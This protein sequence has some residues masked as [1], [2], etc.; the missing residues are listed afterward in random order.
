MLVLMSTVHQLD[1][2]KFEEF[3]QH[4]AK[5]GFKFEQRPHQVFLARYDKLTVNLFK[6]GKVTF[7]GSDPVL[8]REVEWFLEKLGAKRCEQEKGLGYEGRM[9][10]GTDEVGKGDYFG[11]LVVAGV[12]VVPETE[13]A[14]GSIGVRDS[15]K[16]GSDARIAQI[17]TEIM[18]IVGLA[19]YEIILIKPPKYNELHEKLGNVNA[20]L[21]WA[22]ARA[23][24]NLLKENGE[25][26]LA[27]ADQFGNPDYIEKALWAKSRGI[28]LIQVHRGER[29]IAVA[30]ASILA[31]DRFL[32]SMKRMSEENGIEFP[33]GATNV[34][35]SAQQF[36]DRFG[37]DAL[38]KVAK[39]HFSI[40][41]KIS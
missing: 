27:I 17:A 33:R 34:L 28:E 39:L 13:K 23:I 7:G 9:R 36:A 15:K 21:G 35:T 8:Q 30:T 24:K 18:M 22:H 3:R 19:R 11:P 4:L 29:D 2:G 37:K 26:M 41:K 38:G 40:T 32:K 1:L 20:V 14:L 31:R 25:C 12:L 5:V 10:I 16:I 6:L